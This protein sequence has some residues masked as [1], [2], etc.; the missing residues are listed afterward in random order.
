MNKDFC[1][2]SN[3]C[4][5]AEVYIERKIAYNTPFV[6]L[7]IPPSDF[8][9]MANNLQSYLATE[10]FFVKE[11]M[12]KDYQELYKKESYPI[13]LLGDVEIHFLHYTDENQAFEKWNR[14]LARMPKDTSNWFIKGCDREVSD[15]DYLDKM[16]NTIPFHK[17]F[18]SAKERA[19]ID[20]S[21]TITES[22]DDYVTDGKALYHLSKEYFDIDK[23]IDSKGD[24]WE[25]KN[26]PFNRNLIFRFNKL[27]Y[28]LST[29]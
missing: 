4:W 7:F 28:K 22:Y 25:E 18:F 13:A 6:G 11:T 9:K 23:W 17:V 15:W 8:V 10:L 12:F 19:T 26:I 21:I 5:G 14:R 20:H 29:L 3:D 16:W 27:K 2:I 24:T 1:I